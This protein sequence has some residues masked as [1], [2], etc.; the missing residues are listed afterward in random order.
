MSIHWCNNWQHAN[1]VQ[2]MFAMQG[3]STYV[4]EVGFRLAV[5]TE[6][7]QV[8]RLK[9]ESGEVVGEIHPQDFD[10]GF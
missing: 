9:A 10:E 1:E 8:D 3:Q 2:D 7:E 4:V 5:V 6:L